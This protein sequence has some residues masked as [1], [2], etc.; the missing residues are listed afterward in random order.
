MHSLI[1]RN[2]TIPSASYNRTKT[3]KYSADL[4][5]VQWY[6][7]TNMPNITYFASPRRQPSR[8]MQKLRVLQPI[9][10]ITSF[11]VVSEPPAVNKQPYILT[12]QHKFSKLVYVKFVAWA[13]TVKYLCRNR[14][15]KH[16][17]GLFLELIP[18]RHTFHGWFQHIDWRN[19][20]HG[21]LWLRNMI[22]KMM[23]Q[24]EHTQYYLLPRV[25][26]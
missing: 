17:L 20:A 14:L 19:L 5:A 15:I 1:I 13:C 16:I 21:S 11:Y 6:C 7:K 10:R 23:I 3:I 9:E 24:W 2:K 22:K 26:G 12:C 18:Q 25:W 8:K 4:G